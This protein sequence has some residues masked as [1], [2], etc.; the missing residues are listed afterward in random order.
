[1]SGHTQPTR[2]RT[3]PSTASPSAPRLGAFFSSP[4]ASPAAARR[5]RSRPATA[6]GCAF[7]LRAPISIPRPGGSS[8]PAA[9]RRSHSR[10]PSASGHGSF[11]LGG[12]LPTSASA[13]GLSN[14]V[15]AWAKT[16]NRSAALRLAASSPAFSISTL[17]ASQSRFLPASSSTS[18]LLQSFG[19]SVVIPRAESQA[20]FYKSYAAARRA[21][22]GVI[23]DL[24]ESDRRRIAVWVEPWRAHLDTGPSEPVAPAAT[25]TAAT[26]ADG[27]GAEHGGF[28]GDTPRARA[29]FRRMHQLRRGVQR[30]EANIDEGASRLPKSLARALATAQM[31]SLELYHA[32][33]RTPALPPAADPPPSAT[34]LFPAPRVPMMAP[35]VPPRP[36]NKCSRPATAPPSRS[37]PP[38]QPTPAETM[39]RGEAHVPS[40]DATMPGPPAKPPPAM[41][42]P[43]GRARPA[44]AAPPHR[45]MSSASF[46][47]LR[48]RG[49]VPADA[50]GARV[51]WTKNQPRKQPLV[52]AIASAHPGSDSSPPRFAQT[53][54]LRAAILRSSERLLRALEPSPA[55]LA[56]TA[57]VVA[58][59]VER[60][61]ESGIVER[62]RQR[63]E[64]LG[65]EAEMKK[66]P[67][68]RA[69]RVPADAEAPPISLGWAVVGPSLPSNRDQTSRRSMD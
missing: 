64:N 8:S 15:N 52:Q 36:L 60:Q 43:A 38:P 14:T 22:E 61:G 27:T 13:S 65:D 12:S 45:Q 42:T 35:L 50:T 32:H 2:A 66:S 24:V 47:R 44:S 1:L 54:E 68:L 7:S 4:A 29:M 39:W 56:W 33:P 28:G 26:T 59:E 57:V 23:P 6:S 40:V 19:S 69:F 48:A 55:Q 53:S 49:G 9:A 20:S 58:T 17:A 21:H 11:N 41:S 46:S 67:S 30:R 51:D 25:A 16:G 18:S 37:A 31:H 5:S 62:L 10:P 3:C 34:S 63:L